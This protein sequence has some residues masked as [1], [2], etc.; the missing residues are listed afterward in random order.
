MDNLLSQLDQI[1]DKSEVINIVMPLML[2]K[3]HLALILTGGFGIAAG[4]LVYR[5]FNQTEREGM[6]FL[7]KVTALISLFVLQAG[8]MGWFLTPLYNFLLRRANIYS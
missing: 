7:A 1:R 3:Y 6:K 8:A 4:I 5:H 2:A